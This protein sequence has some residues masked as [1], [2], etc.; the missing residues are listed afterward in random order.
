M[1]IERLEDRQLMSVSLDP[2]TKLL[3]ISGTP[4]GDVI[5]VEINGSAIVVKDNGVTH[6]FRRAQVGKLKIQTFAGDDTVALAPNV[7]LSSTIDAGTGKFD[8]VQGG[9]GKD[10]IHL[11]SAAGIA[12][13]GFGAD[14]IHLFGGPSQAYGEA[15]NDRLVSR[16]PGASKSTYDGGAGTDTMSY[17]FA[18]EGMVIKPGLS[19]EYA[20]KNPVA[21]PP[22]DQ[23]TADQVVGCENFFGGSGNDFIIGTGG[24]NALRGNGGNDWIRGLH[25][26]DVIDGGAGNDFL[27]GDEGD[28]KFYARDFTK[29]TIAGGAGTDAAKRDAIDIINSVEGVIV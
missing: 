1:L 5:S 9:S 24:A 29:D 14:A 11:R 25:G 15:G 18:T 28:D 16:H 12:R 10:V 4:G 17:A 2:T 6:P 7:W 8:Q 19:G 21:P 23:H 27:Y 13:G 26:N 3:T 20:A 22:I